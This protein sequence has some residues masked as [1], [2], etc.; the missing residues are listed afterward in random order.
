MTAFKLTV[1]NKYRPD[2]KAEFAKINYYIIVPWQLLIARVIKMRDTIKKH[3]DFMP[4]E[5]DPVAKTPLFIL[6]ACPTKFPGDA[7][8]GLIVTKKTFKHATDRNRAK[9]LLRVWIRANEELMSPEMDYIVIGRRD[10]L[11]ADL[12]TGTAVMKKA[13]KTVRRDARRE[14][15]N[16]RCER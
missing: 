13:M 1:I 8:Y 15:R 10:I 4:V 7:R 16:A 14:T 5:T 2:Y 3:K 6:R 12:P 11:D 9:R